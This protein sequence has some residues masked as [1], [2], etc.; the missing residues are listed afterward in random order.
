ML[1]NLKIWQFQNN[2]LT[3]VFCSTL[4][5]ITVLDRAETSQCFCVSDNNSDCSNAHLLSAAQPP[6]HRYR[7]QTVRHPLHESHALLTSTG[8]QYLVC[9]V[10]CVDCMYLSI[11]YVSIVCMDVWMYVC[12]FL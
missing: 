6:T 10:F 3:E 7:L 11:M 1:V 2:A 5:R 8:I 12:I 4:G 9:T